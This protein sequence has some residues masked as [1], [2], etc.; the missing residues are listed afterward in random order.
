[1]DQQQREIQQG[2]SSLTERLVNGKVTKQ[3]YLNQEQDVRNKI[4]NVNTRI[5]AIINQY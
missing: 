3:E 1:M 4:R 5:S 2:L